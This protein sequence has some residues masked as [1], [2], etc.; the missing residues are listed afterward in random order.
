MQSLDFHIP[1]N[2]IWRDWAGATPKKV[3]KNTLSF[4]FYNLCLCGPNIL[5]EMVRN[6]SW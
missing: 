2:R 3:K 5:I 6:N 4:Y 1:D